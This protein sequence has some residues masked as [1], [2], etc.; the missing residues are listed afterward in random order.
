MNLQMPKTASPANTHP[1][2]LSLRTRGEGWVRGSLKMQRNGTTSHTIKKYKTLL[3]SCTLLLSLLPASAW[4]AGALAAEDT[5]AGIGTSITLGGFAPNT[6]V[7]L[8]LLP[9]LGAEVPLSG[10]TDDNGDAAI[11]INGSEVAVAGSYT[12]LTDS[13]ESSASKTTFTV[14]PDALDPDRSSIETDRTVVFPDGEDTIRVTVILRDRYLNPLEGRPV[15]LIASRTDDRISAD[16]AETDADGQ[17]SFRVSTGKAGSISLRAMDLLSGKLLSDQATISAGDDRGQGGYGM[18]GTWTDSWNGTAANMTMPVGE[19]RGRT[20]YGQVTPVDLQ[21]AGTIDHFRIQLESQASDGTGP[22]TVPRKQDL[23]IRIFAEDAAGRVVEDYTG[24]VRFSST[25]AKAVLPFG[26]R[27]FTFNDLG[28]KSFVLGVRFETPGQQSIVVEDSTGKAKGELTVNVQGTSE[29][30]NYDITISSPAEGSTVNTP[31]V[32]MKGRAPALINLLVTGG[33]EIV[34]G[35][36]DSSGNYQIIVNLLTSL[37]GAT[38]RVEEAAGK[39]FSKD[40]NLVIDVIPPKI[41]S[42][43][44]D[45]IQPTEGQIVKVR[46]KTEAQ[47]PSA[48]VTIGSDQSR[49][50]E[51]PATPGLYEGNFTAPEADTYQPAITILDR[52]GNKAELLSNLVI[53][54][55][56][57]SKVT[58]VIA[59]AKANGVTLKWDALP[60]GEADAYRVYV[61][62][63]PENFAYSLDTKQLSSSATVAGLKSATTYYF[64]VT[65]LKAG[66]ESAEKSDIAEAT[67]MGLKLTVTPADQSLSLAWPS[68]GQDTPLAS[69]VLEYGV[70][71]DV[72]VE[73]RTVN[74]EART[75]TLRDLINGVQ[76]YVRLTPVTTTGQMLKDLA[77]SGEGT[78]S[79]QG[80]GTGAVH[81]SADWPDD[82]PPVAPPPPTKTGP[83]FSTYIFWFAGLGAMILLAFHWHRRRTLKLTTDFLQHMDRRYH[84]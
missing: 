23:S 84:S 65:A 49:L 13:G 15:E 4:S 66:T 83:E 54:A 70:E 58:N 81:G 12:V 52:S 75:Y 41:T 47:V 61:G 42:I 67:V 17:M 77:A 14:S 10:K 45:P 80:F 8:T 11:R 71:P 73:K 59:E 9:P 36:T 40:L 39:Y 62:E 48:S 28:V 18:A 22:V 79:G 44:Y 34:R 72:Y 46:V 82:Y 38:L 32:V 57:P 30:T 69:F 29:P 27:Q 16:S 31:T 63:D 6:S 35:E 26:T 50:Q 74:G 7:H 43:E 19:Y 20:L 51:N 21:S 78:P 24:S 3:A 56:T 2:L 5:V 64:A 55:R 68:V 25:D 37:T 1:Y 53:K 60:A 76:Y 33:R